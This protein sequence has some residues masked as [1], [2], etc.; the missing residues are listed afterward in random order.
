M[1]AALVHDPEVEEIHQELATLLLDE[2]IEASAFGKTG[3]AETLIHKWKQHLLFLDQEVRQFYQSRLD[4]KLKDQITT[5]R[6]RRGIL[7]GRNEDREKISMEINQGRR[8]ISLVGTAGVGK[9]RLAVEVLEDLY[10]P[11]VRSLFCDLTEAKDEL[12]VARVI[13]DALEVRLND[14]NLIGGLLQEIKNQPTLLLLDNAERVADIVARI[15]QTWLQ[16]TENLYIVVT[17]RL[18]INIPEEFC[19][20][21]N[22]LSTLESLELLLR[23]GQLVKPSFNITPE[24]RERAA[25][26]VQNL[27]GLPLAI[28]LAAARLS[29]LT[30]EQIEEHLDERFSLLRSRGKEVP[31]LQAALD[32]SWELLDPWS[33][34]VL[35]QASIFHGGFSLSASKSVIQV[36]GWTEAPAMIDIL[37]DLNEASLLLKE[38]GK[39]SIRYRMLESI[40]AYANQ[41]LKTE[42]TFDWEQTSF[43]HAD[44]Y[45]EYGNKSFLV[46]LQKSSDAQKYRHK[47][48]LELDNLVAG[49]HRGTSVS[50]TKC[51][52]AALKIL[53]LKGPVSLGIEL[54]AEVLKFPDLPDSTRMNL[55]LHRG[56]YLRM[57]GRTSEAKMLFNNEIAS[58]VT[59]E[60]GLDK[61]DP[62]FAQLKESV[63]VAFQEGDFNQAKN[64]AE[65]LIDMCKNSENQAGLG[66][67][68]SNL[69]VLYRS[70]N[71]YEL[72]IP[73]YE[74]AILVLNDAERAVAELCLGNLYRL[75]G[76]YKLAGRFYDTAMTTFRDQEL[77]QQEAECLANRS[78][79]YQAE[80][81]HH[82]AK[83]GYCV[84][85]KKFKVSGDH[86]NEAYYTAELAGLYVIQNRFDEALLKIDEGLLLCKTGFPDVRYFL[87]GVQALCYAKIDDFDQAL[88]VLDACQK[89]PKEMSWAYIEYLFVKAQVQILAQQQKKAKRT[90]NAIEV[91]LD[92]RAL[93]VHSHPG[94]SLLALRFMLYKPRLERSRKEEVVLL[95][96]DHWIA[97]GKIDTD[98]GKFEEGLEKL[99]KAFN[100][101][102]VN[103]DLLGEGKTL[104][105]IG[106]RLN[107]LGEHSKAMNHFQDAL[108][109]FQQI[110]ELQLEGDVL[111]NLG[112]F[113]QNSGRLDQALECWERAIN[114]NRASGDRVAESMSLGNLGNLL[115][116][117]GRMDEAIIML[118]KAL[119]LHQEIGHKSSQARVIA[120]LASIYCIRGE[121]EKSLQLHDQSIT[122]SRTVGTI[123]NQAIFLGN[124]AL[125][126]VIQGDYDKALV[127]FNQ[128]AEINEKIGNRRSLGINFGNIGDVWY[129]KGNLDNSAEYLEKAIGLCDEF[130]SPASGAFRGILG[131]VLAEKGEFNRAKEVLSFGEVL[132][133]P[134][135]LE[136]S[137]FLCRKGTVQL[138]EGRHDEALESLLVVETYIAELSLKEDA[139]LAVM[140]QTLKD[141]LAQEKTID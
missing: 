101:Y 140:A 1:G 54:L 87:Q 72:A 129:R 76:R 36:L 130:K 64:S 97:L 113:Y 37:E 43:R 85:I 88:K 135:P 33:K 28:E 96:A 128:A 95:E 114:I 57:S 105:L 35:A 5:T 56:K 89:F 41:K 19:I 86:R 77:V 30:L 2:I 137:K 110:G 29:M 112:T 15:A 18:R 10:S 42:E 71:E 46:R 90:L 34:S 62:E 73:Q 121:F 82:S 53:D 70:F 9:T 68:Y 83:D 134:I 117:L 75:L 79:C 55:Q 21:L 127:E 102:H 17:S 32:W 116:S 22:P 24:N 51:C 6:L 141:G 16:N 103:F 58:R 124:K 92:E 139:E 7:I 27:D 99:K 48:V 106:S 74:N 104:T 119:L 80:G 50:A 133:Q 20:V 122:I 115:S 45:S 93:P 126:Y 14:R 12:E 91:T 84:A 13:G 131:L 66:E 65:A 120:H 63:N 100:I 67:A 26:V 3:E 107:T 38:Q 49:T 81:D 52:F 61:I 138:L 11:G 109:I 44:Y 59:E 31:A 40:S 39:Y 132:I 108:S 94:K 4:R 8:M 123:L 125:V 23:K 60:H 118:E 98:E 25:R 78:K 136:Y 47:L 69:A 111:R